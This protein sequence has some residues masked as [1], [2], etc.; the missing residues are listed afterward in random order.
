MEALRTGG[1]V[2]NL[3]ATLASTRQVTRRDR[4]RRPRRTAC[5]RVIAEAQDRG[6]Q[7]QHRL[8]GAARADGQPERALRP[9][10]RACRSTSSSPRRPRSC[11]P[12]TRLLASE[13]VAEVPPNLAAALD[14]LR[15]LLAELREGGAVNNLNATLASADRAADAVETAANELPALVANLNRVAGRGRPGARL[16]QP[17]VGHQPRHPAACCRRCATPPARSTRWCSRSS[18]APTRSCSGDEHAPPAL[19]GRGRSRSPPAASP[20]TTCCRRRRPAPSRAAPVGSVVVADL[21]LPAYADALEVATPDRPRHPRAAQAL[22]LGRHPAPG[23]DPP[24]RRRARR[25]PERAGRHRALARLRL[26]R[27]ARRGHAS[28]G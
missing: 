8:R 16:G 1:A 11:R 22:A 3:N 26:A 24:P 19:P 14:E 23:D 6:R 18:G 25:P 27:P 9:G 7:R 17:R 2:D 28:T 10:G 4:R 13:G 21:S 12:P 5:R 20:P 15:G